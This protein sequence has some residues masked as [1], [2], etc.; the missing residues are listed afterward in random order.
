MRGGLVHGHVLRAHGVVTVAANR[1]QIPHFIGSAT[2][3][4]DHVADIEVLHGNR[5]RSATEAR[6]AFYVAH[7]VGPDGPSLG[8]GPPFALGWHL[9]LISSSGFRHMGNF[10]PVL[11]FCLSETRQIKR[12]N[13]Y[14]ILLKDYIIRITEWFIGSMSL[15]VRTVTFM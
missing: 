7:V 14:D 15:N 9:I 5:F 4:C 8:G 10:W 6:A 12:Q 1:P 13:L 3:E 2:R 11:S